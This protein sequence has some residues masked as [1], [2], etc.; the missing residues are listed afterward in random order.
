MNC[1][2]KRLCAST[3]ASVVALSLC[4]VVVP[5][6]AV[7]KGKPAEPKADEPV[8]DE[9]TIPGEAHVAMKVQF[10]KFTVDGKEWENYEFVDGAKTLIVRGLNRADDHTL[11]LTPRESGFDAYS[12]TLKTADFKKT[13]VKSK[14]NTKTLT[15]KAAYHVDF[16]KGADKKPDEKKPD[17]KKPDDKKPDEKK[18]DAK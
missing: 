6:V 16:A 18:G 10:V 14:G 7:A 4:A 17:E 13:V 2:I 12:L 11:V 1:N 9:D 5:S 8:V 15:F 3:L